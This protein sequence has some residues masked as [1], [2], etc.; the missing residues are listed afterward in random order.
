MA[1]YAVLY[2]GGVHL[3]TFVDAKLHFKLRVVSS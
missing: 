3:G 2:Q 1:L